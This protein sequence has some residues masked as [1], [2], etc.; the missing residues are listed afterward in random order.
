MAHTIIKTPFGFVGVAAT[1]KGVRQV[2]LPRPDEGSVWRELDSAEDDSPQAKAYVKSAAQKLQ[3][4]F[5]GENVTFDEPLDWDGQSDFFRRVWTELLT[6]PR[7]E[8]L[9]YNELGRRVGK[10]RA[11][12][13]VGAAMAKNPLPVI[14][15]CHRVLRSDG[16]LG[17]FGGGL[18]L[19]RRMLELEQGQ[20]GRL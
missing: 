8:T 3:R 11:A 4:Y 15:P 6:V 18:P 1:S 2:L 7:G 5:R 9:S 16:S 14:V 13:A 19:K 20:G 12:R 17:G 10:P